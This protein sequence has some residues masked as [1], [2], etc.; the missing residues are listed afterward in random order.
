MHNSSPSFS[1]FA[2]L[3]SSV[4]TPYKFENEFFYVGQTRNAYKNFVGRS[5]GRSYVNPVRRGDN[6]IQMYLKNYSGWVLVGTPTGDES[7]DSENNSH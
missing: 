6:I 3:I 5:E 4:T 2:V 7:S 1:I